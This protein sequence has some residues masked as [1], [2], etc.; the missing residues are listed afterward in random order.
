MMIIL[1]IIT[2]FFYY[3]IKGVTVRETKVL[4]IIT[5]VVWGLNM[6]VLMGTDGGFVKI[7]MTIYFIYSFLDY[8]SIQFTN[9]NIIDLPWMSGIKLKNKEVYLNYQIFRPITIIFINIF[10]L[11]KKQPL[12]GMN[13]VIE[14]DINSSDKTEIKIK[15]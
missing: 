3:G 10:L 2:W 14:V 11:V 15:L 8:L 7:F 13:D 1:L 9:K 6:L 4:A 5:F 12:I